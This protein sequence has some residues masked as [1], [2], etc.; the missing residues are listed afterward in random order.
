MTR[1][2]AH[3]AWTCTRTPCWRRDWCACERR[4]RRGRTG[5]PCCPRWNRR[6]R[7]WRAWSGC[8]DGTAV[9][10]RW[11][12][13]TGSTCPYRGS[14][15][16]ALGNHG[17]KRVVINIQIIRWLRTRR[18]LMLFEIDRNNGL[19]NKHKTYRYTCVKLQKSMHF[20]EVIV[21]EYEIKITTTI[22]MTKCQRR[23]LGVMEYIMSCLF[24]NNN[25]N[26]MFICIALIT[27]IGS[28]ALY[29]VCIMFKS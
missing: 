2:S 17:N 21:I 29:I 15:C 8:R 19:Q 6:R 28:T 14:P 9:G 16:G 10:A 23:K 25:N 7:R 24:N 3:L 20:V 1:K 22:Q 12:S 11:R 18:A 27:Q 13:S 4:R 26:N 5:C